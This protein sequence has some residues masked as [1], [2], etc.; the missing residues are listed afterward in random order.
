MEETYYYTIM[1][2]KVRYWA[3][4]MAQWLRVLTALLEVLSSITS[5]HMVAYSHL[6]WDMM[7]PP[8]V[9]EDSYSVFIYIYKMN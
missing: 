5:N 9:T 6:Q 7:P 4:E 1:V 8:G 3:R 2:R